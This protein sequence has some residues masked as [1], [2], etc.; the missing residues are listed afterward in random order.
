MQWTS[1]TRAYNAIC[2]GKN[3]DANYLLRSPRYARE[4]YQILGKIGE[5]A[6]QSVVDSPVEWIN[7]YLV[8]TMEKL[9]SHPAQ[10]PE[11][12]AML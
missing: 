3:P 9:S 12:P 6:M 11:T 8:I 2:V 5:A 7:H 4:V 1:D 10:V